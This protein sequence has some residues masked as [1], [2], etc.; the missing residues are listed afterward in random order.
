M[1]TGT[2][3][4]AWANGEDEFCIA[5]VKHILALE[6]ACDAGVAAIFGRLLDGAWMLN[7]VRETI[8]LGLIGGGKSPEKA[9]AIV[10]LHVDG[11][12][13]AQSLLIAQKVLEAALVGVPGESVGKAAAAGARDPLSSGMTD[14][15]AAPASTASEPGSD[16]PPEK[17]TT[18]PSGSSLPASP[19]TTRPT[20][21]EPNPSP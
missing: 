14:A 20:A 15:S 12:P 8:R 16:T 10:K 1:T 6:H 11:N 3:T 18:V 21:A 7:D 13:L 5:Q 19:A 4:I 2:V 9:M 17:S